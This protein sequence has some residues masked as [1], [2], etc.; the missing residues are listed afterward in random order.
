MTE[1]TEYPLRTCPPTAEDIDVALRRLPAGRGREAAL[2]LALPVTDVVGI[3]ARVASGYWCWRGAQVRSGGAGAAA[4]LA[5]LAGRD[6]DKFL[7]LGGESLYWVR[8][9][10][11]G[12]YLVAF[13]SDTLLDLPLIRIDPVLAGASYSI[14]ARV[15][16]GQLGLDGDTALNVRVTANGWL[17][18]PR[19]RWRTSRSLARC[20]AQVIGTR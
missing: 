20:L 14:I 9:I 7:D 1:L 5:S 13:G 10:R 3:H 11:S 2:M 16:S 17:V 12:A 8:V 18:E 15:A 19:S 6:D 4:L